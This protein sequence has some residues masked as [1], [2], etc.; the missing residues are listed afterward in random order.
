MT[1]PGLLCGGW[2]VGLGYNN[3]G[4][5]NMPMTSTTTTQDAH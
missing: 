3:E 4:Y 1:V 2:G 5:K